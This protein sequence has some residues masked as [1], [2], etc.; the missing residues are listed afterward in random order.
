MRKGTDTTI[1][2]P[3]SL[4]RFSG[5]LL[6]QGGALKTKEA[7][8]ARIE[9]LPE[10]STGG[11]CHSNDEIENAAKEVEGMMRCVRSD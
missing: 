11:E 9:M 1:V 3:S 7:Q 5:V 2:Q 10:E 6:G 8:V 4:Q